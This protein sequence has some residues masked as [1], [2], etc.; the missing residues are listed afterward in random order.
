[1]GMIQTFLDRRLGITSN[2]RHPL[3]YEKYELTPDDVEFLE[4]MRGATLMPT[5]VRLPSGRTVTAHELDQW[6]TVPSDGFD[7][8]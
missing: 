7:R 5:L 3:W 4:G 8:E 1:M 6:F 2:I